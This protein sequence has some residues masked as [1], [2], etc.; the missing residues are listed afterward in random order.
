MA[1]RARITELF[2][3]RHPI[4]LGGMHHQ[5]QSGIVASPPSRAID[6]HR[7]PRLS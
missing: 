2:G 7:W 6:L 3:I 1:F 4:L 5:G